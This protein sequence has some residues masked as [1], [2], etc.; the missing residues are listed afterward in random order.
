MVHY[1]QSYE[2]G[3]P[4]ETLILPTVS[5]YF[6]R[7]IHQYTNRYDKH[8]YYCTEYNY[9]VKSRTNTF[10]KYPTTM[11][12]EDK[13]EYTDTRPL[14]LIFNF[15]DKIAFIEYNKEKFAK[16]ERRMFS[17]AGY[18][19]DEKIH[20]YIPITDLTILAEK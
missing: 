14:I 3:K 8:D 1:K 12:T 19:W 7:E 15:T 9:E 5:S 10:A 2:F 13:T 11:I 16:Y 6:S 4:Q 17:R 18:T 20:V